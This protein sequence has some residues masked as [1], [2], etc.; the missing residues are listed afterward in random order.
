MWRL[1][2]DT[3]ANGVPKDVQI[4]AGAPSSLVYPSDASKGFAS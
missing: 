1:L 3:F 4:N 2:T